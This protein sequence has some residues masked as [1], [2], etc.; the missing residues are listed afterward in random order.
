MARTENK[1]SKAAF[2]RSLPSTMSAKEVIEKAKAAGHKLS[3][4]YVYVIRSKDN[5]SA[6]T[7]NRGS[8]A[9]RP[10]KANGNGGAS[11]RALV[12]AAL[13]L[14]FGRARQLLDSAQARIRQSISQRNDETSASIGHGLRTVACGRCGGMQA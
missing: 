11:E 4:A 7:G 12:N 13:E 6:A 14:G 5:T 2:V 9:G 10:G 8:K 1:K 3:S